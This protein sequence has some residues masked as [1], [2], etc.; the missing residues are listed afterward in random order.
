MAEQ[1]VAEAS[2][3]AEEMRSEA[4]AEAQSVRQ[5]AKTERETLLRRVRLQC[6]TSA[7]ALEEAFTTARELHAESLARIDTAWK[8]L[9]RSLPEA[10]GDD[11]TPP[12]LAAKINRIVQ[13]LE[14]LESV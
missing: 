6:E 8:Q 5:A 3:E 7:V 11:E 9:L 14:D 1:Y 12:D 13:E 10:E 4:D 2:E